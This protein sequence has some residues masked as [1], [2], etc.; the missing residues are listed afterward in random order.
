MVYPNKMR[1]VE[2]LCVISNNSACCFLLLD[3]SPV[4]FKYIQLC[5]FNVSVLC[6]Y[7]QHTHSTLPLVGTFNSNVAKGN[8]IS[9]A[10]E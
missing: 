2:S 1:T 8:V 10:C 6:V 4:C 7:V 5:I 9:S 3:S